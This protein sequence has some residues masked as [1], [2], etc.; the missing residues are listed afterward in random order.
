MSCEVS[1]RIDGL[2]KKPHQNPEETLFFEAL[3]SMATTPAVMLAK[4]S[5]F[6]PGLKKLGT[7]LLSLAVLF[8]MAEGIYAL[9]LPS[10]LASWQHK[11]VTR[12][13]TTVVT[14]VKPTPVPAVPAPLKPL[15]IVTPAEGIRMHST[16]IMADDNVNGHLVTNALLTVEQEVDATWYRVSFTDL[17]KGF[18]TGYVLR[19]LT[20]AKQ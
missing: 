10:R 20:V 18:Q 16:P 11:T 12:P 7:A 4:R 1:M 3:P 2:S 9:R 8:G 13:Q 5:V 6:G 14:Q 19:G 15:V 17:T